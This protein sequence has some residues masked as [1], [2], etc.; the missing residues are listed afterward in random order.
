MASPLVQFRALPGM[1]AALRRR[2]VENDPQP[3]DLS[4]IARRDLSRYYVML[5]VEL[6]RAAARLTREQALVLCDVLM[7]SLVDEDL[8]LVRYLD[9]EVSDGLAEGLARKWEADEPALLSLVQ[10][11]TLAQ[12]LAVVDAVER[13]HRLDGLDYDSA[14]L[15]VGL[16]PRPG[17]A[18]QV[19]A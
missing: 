16:L 1:L 10:G 11:W 12:R 2:T 6:A 3:R 19:P 7:G 15:E 5:D 17:L 18:V 14:L 13:F 9:H 4:E 8:A